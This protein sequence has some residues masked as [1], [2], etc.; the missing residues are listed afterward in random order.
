[1]KS[2]SYPQFR[3]VESDTAQGLTEELNRIV[4]DLKDKN[5][6]VTFDGSLT[7]RIAYTETEHDIPEELSDEYRLQGVK[8]TCDDCP[9]FERAKKRDGSEDLRK[10]FGTC[11]FYGLEHKRSSACEKLFQM[12]NSGEVK[13]CL[14]N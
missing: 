3:I 9:Y 10:N 13:L 8:L 12:I 7:A 6:Q 2:I 5:P 4:K 1:M 11:P 14:E